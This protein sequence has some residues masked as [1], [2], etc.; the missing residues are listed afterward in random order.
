M[1]DHIARLTKELKILRQKERRQKQ[2]DEY[3]GLS[4]R[5]VMLTLSAYFLSNYDLDLAQRVGSMLL[6]RPTKSGKKKSKA[7][8]GPMPIRDWFLAVDIARFDAVITPEK[9]SEHR[10]LREVE[11]L[12]SEVKTMRWVRDENFQRG[13]APANDDVALQFAKSMESYGQGS[14]VDA[15]AEAAMSASKKRRRTVRQW[16]RRLRRRWGSSNTKLSTT[17]ALPRCL[18]GAK[19]GRAIR[20]LSG[21]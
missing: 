6:N 1:Q 8:R 17:D 15:L 9:A 4:D 20:I 11:K 7:H 3:W 18:Q 2:R 14:Q 12:I 19:A 5:S 10:L 21:F 13:V 16:A